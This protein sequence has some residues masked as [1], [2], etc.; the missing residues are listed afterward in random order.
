MAVDGGPPAPAVDDFGIPIA[1]GP[2]VL[3]VIKKV[4][5][6]V[7]CTQHNPV[8]VFFTSLEYWLTTLT[9]TGDCCSQES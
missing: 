9:L 2:R 5:V 1:T 7:L 6:Q 3:K 4:E 8:R